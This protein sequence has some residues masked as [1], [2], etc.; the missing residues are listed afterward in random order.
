MA[1]RMEGKG[2]EEV[3]RQLAALETGAPEMA[4]KILYVG[5]GVVADAVT[6]G[7]EEIGTE[8]FRYAFNDSLRMPSPEE[9][10]AL[11][12]ATAILHFKR[13]GLGSSTKIYIAGGYANVNGKRKPV[14]MIANAINSGTSFLHKQPFFRKAVRQS[15]AQAIAAMQKTA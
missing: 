1:I 7:I 9:K 5:A 13:D 8:P 6:K 2:L 4:S 14:P 11:R 12:N 15:E 3:E 10:E